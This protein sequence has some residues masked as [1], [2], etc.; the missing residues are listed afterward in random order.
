MVLRLVVILLILMSISYLYNDV[1]TKVIGLRSALDSASNS[2]NTTGKDIKGDNILGIGPSQVIQINNI[3]INYDKN[4]TIIPLAPISLENLE[5]LKK[6]AVIKV[7]LTNLQSGEFDIDSSNI[8][9]DM[10][11]PSSYIFAKIR[12]G[13]PLELHLADSEFNKKNSISIKPILKISLPTK[14]YEGIYTGKVLV[15]VVS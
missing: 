13:N 14:A 9:I 12:K 8:T 2:I 6:S 5:K 3:K 15:E 11:K 10:E 4:E 1:S 7:H